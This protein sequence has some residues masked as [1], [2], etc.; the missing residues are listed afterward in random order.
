MTC[1]NREKYISE[2]IESV[3]S[4]TFSDFELIIVDDKS[5]DQTLEI[6]KNYETKDQRI[7]VYA[8]ETNL[9]DYYNRNKAASYARGK[10]LKY[11]D[12]DDLFYKHS[13][14]V[15]VDFMVNNPDVGY[16]VISPNNSTLMPFPHLFKP[17]ESIR[18]HFFKQHFLD[19]APTGSIFKTEI[20]HSV[21]GFSG[22]RM[23]G[24]IEMGLKIASKY[25][26]MIL[27]PGLVFWREH[28]NQEVFIGLNNNMYPPL[29]KEIL[30]SFFKS[31][32]EEILTK[33]EIQIIRRKELHSSITDKLKKVIKHLLNH[34]K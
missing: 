5:T 31:I 24:D 28:G 34:N 4:S 22:K 25:S 9:G 32:N 27:P 20:F 19:C 15:Y 29:M 2:A 23:I 13:L 21:G 18:H 17:Q 8:N 16:G 1:Y 30:N 11:L 33:D 14:Q 26:V 12:S 6:A 10:Y 3:L 7:K